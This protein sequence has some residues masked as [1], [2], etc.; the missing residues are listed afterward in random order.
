MTPRAATASTER[1]GRTDHTGHGGDAGHGDHAAVF[2][3][4]FLGSLVLTVPVLAL[5]DH[6]GGAVGLGP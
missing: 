1:A 3:R 6:I 5:S 2:R 4:R